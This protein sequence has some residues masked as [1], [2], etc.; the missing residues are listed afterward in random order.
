MEIFQHICICATYMPDFR[1]FAEKSVSD[2][3]GLELQ[4]ALATMCVV[5]IELGS[6]GR[7]VSALNH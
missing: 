1:S 7:V 6:Y 4:N 5:R 2:P 3:L